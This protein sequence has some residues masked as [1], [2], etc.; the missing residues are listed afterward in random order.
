MS[1]KYQYVEDTETQEEREEREGTDN[2]IINDLYD[3]P[4]AKQPKDRVIKIEGIKELLSVQ[5]LLY[6]ARARNAGVSCMWS[7]S[8]IANDYIYAP[9]SAE[10]HDIE[11]RSVDHNIL[12]WAHQ[13]MTQHGLYEKPKKPTKK[14]Q[15]Q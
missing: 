3:E 14:G 8:D 13:Y 9:G 10:F 7:A 1:G 11:S 6:Y 2:E 4:F 12:F 15:K 5:W